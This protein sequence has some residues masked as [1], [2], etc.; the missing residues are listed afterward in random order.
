MN[1]LIRTSH[2]IRS[3]Q[4]VSLYYPHD[5]SEF[6]HFRIVDTPGVNAIGGIEEQTKKFIRQAR[7]SYLFVTMQGS[8][9]VE[10]HSAMHFGE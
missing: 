6:K 10:V 9:K 2:V 8:W 3:P 1:T 5:I 4:Q 7:C